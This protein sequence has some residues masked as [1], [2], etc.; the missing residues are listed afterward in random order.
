M[1]EEEREGREEGGEGV[2][3]DDEERGSR[4]GLD[5]HAV[6]PLAIQLSSLYSIVNK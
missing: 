6:T 1:A 2:D 4:L 3:R 5:G